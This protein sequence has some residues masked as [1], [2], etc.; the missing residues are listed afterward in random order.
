MEKDEEKFNK[1]L[2]CDTFDA[3]EI[4]FLD[5]TLSHSCHGSSYLR[6]LLG[7]K[8]CSGKKVQNEIA[9]EDD[10]GGSEDK[11]RNYFQFSDTLAS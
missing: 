7:E 1:N 2:F 11:R 3:C 4:S 9:S 10:G 5:S 6:G 8:P